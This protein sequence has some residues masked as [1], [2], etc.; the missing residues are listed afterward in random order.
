MKCFK[1]NKHSNSIN[2]IIGLILLLFLYTQYL[3]VSQM[4]VPKKKK[5]TDLE[6]YSEVPEE[7]SAIKVFFGIVNKGPV[8]ETDSLL[9]E[10]KQKYANSL[11]MSE[12]DTL[13]KEK[14][15]FK[16]GNKCP[17]FCL[18]DKNDK[19]VCLDKF[20]GKVVFIEFWASY[21]SPCISNMKIIAKLKA[22]SVLNK[23]IVFLN[24][25]LDK[26]KEKFTEAIQK[27]QLE[28]I[29]LYGDLKI[30]KMFQI[31]AI[32]QSFIIDS[33]GQFFYYKP[34]NP[35]DPKRE[36]ALIDILNNAK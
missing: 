36:Q 13:Y 19:K 12:L 4:S 9:S 10:F 23:N 34:P 5:I 27:H 29:Q 20:K 32:P 22:E 26:E 21:C 16:K 31:E 11:F 33:K 2:H 25:N 24:I 28:D 17:N 30:K 15:F 6:H 7:A 8:S 18:R 35:Y 1:I 3:S 14:L